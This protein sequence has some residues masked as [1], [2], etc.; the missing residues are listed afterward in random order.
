MIPS[1]DPPPDARRRSRPR[2]AMSGRLLHGIHR[3][4]VEVVVR[5]L[6]EGGAKVRLTLATGVRI[7]GPTVLRIGSVDR[8]CTVAWQSGDEVGLRFE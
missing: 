5:N 3:E 6:T 1:D 2:V 8:P 4:S 7:G